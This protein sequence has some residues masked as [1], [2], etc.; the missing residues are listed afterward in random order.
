M[1]QTLACAVVLAAVAAGS[2]PGIRARQIQP[3]HNPTVTFDAQLAGGSEVPPVSTGAFG[4][5]AFVFD[6]NT[7]R[8][9][10]TVTVW[11]FPPSVS[12]AHIHL[13]DAGVNGPVLIGLT[14]PTGLSGDGSWQC[15]LDLEDFRAKPDQGL[16]TA[17]D[18]QQ[19]LLGNDGRNLYVNVHSTI[20]PGGELRG[21]LA[22]RP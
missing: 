22:P 6:P 2:S 12:A 15:D 19:I 1:K 13:G 18:I 20:N 16:T 10:C 21:Q 3:S 8:L 5:A 7:Q 17:P 11:N 4:T 9:T 14:P